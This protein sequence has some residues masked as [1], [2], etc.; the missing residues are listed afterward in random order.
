[1][2]SEEPCKEERRHE[3][4]IASHELLPRDLRI[5][6]LSIESGQVSISVSSA[7][8][9]SICPVCG[10]H[11]SRAHSRYHRNVRDLP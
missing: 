10:R 4:A 8:Q 3:D 5:E 1:L 11:S 9:G 2:G 6:N 7:A